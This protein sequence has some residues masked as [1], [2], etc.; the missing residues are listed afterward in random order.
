[1]KCPKCGSPIDKLSIYSEPYSIYCVVCNIVWSADSLAIFDIQ[2]AEI[3]R[4]QKQIGD[5]TTLRDQLMKA[6]D[7]IDRLNKA[8]SLHEEKDRNYNAN[9]VMWK[10]EIATLK[11]EL[12]KWK[13]KWSLNDKSKEIMQNRIEHGFVTTK[14][15]MLEKLMLVVTECAEAAEDVRHE[16]WEHFGEELTDIMIRVMDIGAT[17]DID[18]ENEIDKKHEINKGRPYLHGKKTTA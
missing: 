10:H 4:L 18:L 5:E 12:E 9:A 15:I 13:L 6:A 1:M 16:E 11:D 17:L 7:E 3:E 14:E 2:Q 8:L